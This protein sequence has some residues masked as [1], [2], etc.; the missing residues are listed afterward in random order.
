MKILVI[1]YGSIGKRNINNLLSIPRIKVLVLTKQKSTDP[2]LKKCL[3]YASLEKCIL[4]K[5]S[6]AIIATNTS[7]HIDISLK[8]AKEGIDLFIEK[9]LSN[10]IKNIT[11]LSK[12]VK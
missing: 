8:L 9:P 5:P 7:N 3:V 10:N 12:I 6:A 2:I 4:E 1:G 11:Q